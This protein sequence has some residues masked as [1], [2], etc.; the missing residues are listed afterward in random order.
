VRSGPGGATLG[1]FLRTMA[2]EAAIAALFL[3]AW[4]LLTYCFGGGESG[5][6]YLTWH[7]QR[8]LQVEAPAAFPVLLIDPACELG[9]GY[10]SFNLRGELADRTAKLMALLMP[11]TALLA[12]GISFRGFLSASRGYTAIAPHAVAS[13]LLIWVA[14]IT[15]NKV[16]SPQYLIWVAPL[17]PLL[18]LRSTSERLWAILLLFAMIAT[19]LIFPCRYKPDLIGDLVSNH[20]ITWSGPTP[21]GVFLLGVKSVA[22][23]AATVWL[24]ILMWQKGSRLGSTHARR[25]PVT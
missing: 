19:T 1:R 2:R 4:P 23:F 21:L 13:A 5:F 8:G 9:E 3:A 12:L 11:L 6:L 18:P 17:V 16:G 20:P 14:F 24:A 15:F 22:L 10:G 7:S 25:A